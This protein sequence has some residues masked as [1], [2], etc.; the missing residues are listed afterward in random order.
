[1]PIGFKNGTDGN[2]QVAIDAIRSSRSAHTFLSVTKQG[3]AAIVES[4]GN[5]FGH[6]ILRGGKTPNFEKQYVA[7]AAEQLQKAGLPTRLM[8]DCSHGNSSKQHARQSIVAEDI[9]EQLSSGREHAERIMGVMLES[10]IKDG[11]Q[12][13]PEEGPAGLEYGVSITDA[14][15][16]WATTVKALDNLRK[17]VQQRR[18]NRQN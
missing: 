16:D 12:N 3:L 18:Q 14:C 4:N 7:L 8:I 13:V 1:M 6:V 11:R 15:I 5:P 9:V 17:G 2:I 10:N